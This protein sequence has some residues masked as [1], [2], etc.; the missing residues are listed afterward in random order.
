MKRFF[1]RDAVLGA[2][3]QLD[4]EQAHHLR[5]VMRLGTGDRVALFDG[6]GKEYE[7]VIESVGADGVAC[8]I[9]VQLDT[10][11]EL[12]VDVTVYQAV[13]KGGHFDYAVQKAVEAGAGQ[14]VPFVSAR[15]VR[16]PAN[17]AKFQT[18]AARIAREAARQCGRSVV[19]EVLPVVSIADVAHGASDS[20]MVVAYEDEHGRTLRQ[21]LGHGC[22]KKMSIVVGP[23]GGFAPEEIAQLQDAGAL[24]VSLGPRILRA[25]TAATYMLAQ[26]GYACEQ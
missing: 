13:L 18:R 14:I 25:E 8:R 12:P 2:I 6:T 1:S 22:P 4:G 5:D 24:C 20:L 23:E 21:V 17:D 10:S 26:I 11:S 16:V 15:C 7:A 19:P 3:V 9:A